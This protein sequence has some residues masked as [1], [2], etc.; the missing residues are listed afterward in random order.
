MPEVYVSALLLSVAVFAAM[1]PVSIAIR[2]VS[3]VDAW[4]GPGFF[5]A[6]LL[7]FLSTDASGQRASL[8]L[9]LVGLWAARLGFI[10]L[11]RRLRHGAEDNRYVTIRASWGP[12]FWW[13]SLFIVFLLQGFL[14]WIVVFPAMAAV[15]AAPTP[16]GL[17]GWLGAII[18]LGGFALEAKADAEL[19]AFKKTAKPGDLLQTGLRRH[20]RHPNYTGEMMFWWGAWLIAA[21][22]G[23]WWTVFAPL[24]LTVLL[25]KVSGAG[26]TGGHLKKTK[27]E[28]RSYAAA[29]PAFLPKPGRTGFS[30]T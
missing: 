15:S 24:T 19:D 6:T 25:T 5:A 2:D 4:W 7:V 26:I 22:G 20:V 1:W 9:A 13:K 23:A 21:D 8:I 30:G 14:Q 18:A 27:P 17:I 28:F 10:L 11:R 16:I 12:S 29:T 3:I